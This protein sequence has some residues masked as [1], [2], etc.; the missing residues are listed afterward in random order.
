M[1]TPE[2]EPLEINDYSQATGFEKCCGQVEGV[3]REWKREGKGG[4]V[5]TVMLNGEELVVRYY[6]SGK[7]DTM[8]DILLADHD[9]AEQT[10]E[11]TRLY[12]VTTYVVIESLNGHASSEELLSI[13]NLAAAGADF[14]IP[15]FAGQIGISATPHFST[16][17]H[18]ESRPEAP[19]NCT[20]LEELMDLFYLNLG[21]QS[22]LDGDGMRVTTRFT[23]HNKGYSPAEWEHLISV[24]NEGKLEWGTVCDP[25]VG[26]DTELIWPVASEAGLI[27]NNVWSAFDLLSPPVARL[28]LRFSTNPRPRLTENLRKF[29][30]LILESTYKRGESGPLVPPPSYYISDTRRNASWASTASSLIGNIA[31]HAAGPY[32]DPQRDSDLKN[33]LEKKCLCIVEKCCQQD[34]SYGAAS[35]L[36]RLSLEAAV[37]FD[38]LRDVQV[39]WLVFVEFL[40]TRWE[41]K[42]PIPFTQC[43]GEIDWDLPLVEQKIILLNF[44]IKQVSECRESSPSTPEAKEGWGS[45][46]DDDFFGTPLEDGDM[47]KEGNGWEV[48]EINLQSD[49]IE[50]KTRFLFKDAT[51]VVCI[52]FT[53]QPCP[54]TSD[55]VEKTQQEMASLGS[56]RIASDIRESY[57]TE[58]LKSDMEAFKAANQSDHLILADFIQWHSPRDIDLSNKKDFLSERMSVSGNP[59][60]KLWNE[61]KPVPAREQAPLFNPAAKGQTAMGWLRNTEIP[62]VVRCMADKVILGIYDCL[63]V[64]SYGKR[65]GSVK[66][67]SDSVRKEILCIL[68]TENSDRERYTKA[69]DALEKLEVCISTATSLLDRVMIFVTKSEDAATALEIADCFT[70]ASSCTLTKSQWEVLRRVALPISGAD[71]NLEQVREPDRREFIIRCV[72]DRPPL[73]FGQ[74]AMPPNPDVE[75]CAQ[76]LYV[77]LGNDEFKLSMSLSENT[78]L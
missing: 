45:G 70:H 75:P 57:H 68:K 24:V 47:E 7:G 9:F 67:M 48:P 19:P 28:S 65:L 13:L 51:C 14:Y 74:P 8:R 26:M 40:E 31:M 29:A 34:E 36:S 32:Y 43:E 61:A 35:L 73:D 77:S 72:C 53:Q 15:C 23:Y 38:S 42:K 60:V 76:R 44:C 49:T 25:I 17:F 27:D 66:A 69:S 20:T 1:T 11:H 54:A 52:P 16:S 5:E 78:D 71:G 33:S 58:A 3:L 39:L 2:E 18:A 30:D 59:W 21:L 22:T 12:G 6:R 41:E 37:S 56:S 10:E 64:S 63:S 50:E 55:C 46:S 4:E 62:D